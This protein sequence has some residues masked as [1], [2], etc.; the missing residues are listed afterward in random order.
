MCRVATADEAF[1]AGQQSRAQVDLRLIPKLQPFVLKRLLERN[2]GIRASRIGRL[3]IKLR[4]IERLRKASIRNGFCRG[5][6]ILRP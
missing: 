4:A 6:R 2:L 1:R 3:L 5:G